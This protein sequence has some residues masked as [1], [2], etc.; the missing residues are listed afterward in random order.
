[1][2]ETSHRPW[3]LPSHPWML[4]MHW[5]DPLFMHWPVPCEALRAAI[6]PS[7]AIDTFDGTAWIGVLPFRMTGVRP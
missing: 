4:A 1:M 6:P 7:L 2:T 3:E 5:H